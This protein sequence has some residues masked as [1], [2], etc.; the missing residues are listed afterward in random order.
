[1]E[2]INGGNIHSTSYFRYIGESDG[3]SE[4]LMAMS[5]SLQAPLALLRQQYHKLDRII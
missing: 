2:G 3:A 4:Q 1:M 5:T